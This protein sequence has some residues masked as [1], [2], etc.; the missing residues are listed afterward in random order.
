MRYRTQSVAYA[1]FVVALLLYG[2]QMVF[3]LL[4]IAKYLG[5]DPIVSVPAVR[6]EQGDPHQPA[7]RLGAD[8]LHGRDLLAGARGV[9]HRALLAAAGLLAARAL[10]PRRA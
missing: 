1:Y 6:R 8:R 7:H 2:L 3:G 10:D 9:A 4:S 5:P